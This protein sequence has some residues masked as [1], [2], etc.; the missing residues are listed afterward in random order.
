[1]IYEI[2]KE[3]EE[4]IKKLLEIKTSAFL[5]EDEKYG[6]Q[7]YADL[8]KIEREVLLESIY[9]YYTNLDY[10]STCLAKEIDYLEGEKA[11]TDRRIDALKHELGFILGVDEKYEN[12]I[13]WGTSESVYIKNIEKIPEKY[14]KIETVQSVDKMSLKRDL[15]LE[16]VPGAALVRE[17]Y[18]KIKNGNK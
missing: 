1:M 5:Q 14:I 2:D 12:K 9:R 3:I 15:K 10:R 17:K 13:S 6:E 11:Q 4:K 18:L 16:E 7:V 8:A